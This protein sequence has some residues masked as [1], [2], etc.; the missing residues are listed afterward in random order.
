MN[1]SQKHDADNQSPRR[2]TGLPPPQ[3]PPPQSREDSNFRSRH[4]HCG[5]RLALHFFRYRQSGFL[6]D[7]GSHIHQTHTRIDPSARAMRGRQLE[8]QGHVQRFVVEKDSVGVLAVRAQRLTVVG[9]HRNQ[10]FV[11]KTVLA[12]LVQQ[13]AHGRVGIGDFAVIRLRSKPRLK[14]RWRIVRIVRIVKM[15]P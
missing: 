14:R 3:S 8:Q 6:Q 7:G 13:F 2:R 5:E 9:H 4:H 10:G 15:H 12:D 1:S 11:V